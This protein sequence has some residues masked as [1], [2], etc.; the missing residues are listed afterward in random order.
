MPTNEPPKPKPKT[1]AGASPAETAAPQPTPL[2]NEVVLGPEWTAERLT[3]L[4][5]KVLGVTT[6]TFAYQGEQPAENPDLTVWAFLNALQGS[7][8]KGILAIDKNKV[9]A[10]SIYFLAYTVSYLPVLDAS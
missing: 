2:P 7:S 3:H 6:R 1:G 4:P 10:S 8:A 5:Q 9:C